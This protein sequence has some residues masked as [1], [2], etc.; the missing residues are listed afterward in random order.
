MN[1]PQ[2]LDVPTALARTLRIAQ[3]LE[4]LH[5]SQRIH[6]ALQPERLAFAPDG[7]LQLTSAP[8]A[9]VTL[10][11]ARL[12]YASPEQ[13]GRL[14]VVDARSDLH[15]L[16]LILYE[17]LL[18][19]PAF[20]SHDPLDLAYH[21]MAVAPT[22]PHALN[23]D[24]PPALSELVLRLLAKSPDARYATARGLAD[25]LQH[26]LQQLA[27]SGRI[28]PFALC[29]TDQG[30]QFLIPDRLYGRDQEIA[31][32]T[33]IF[34]RAVAGEVVLCMV[35]GYSGIGKSA[36]VRALRGNI[37]A[38][39][40]SL[41]EGKF[42]QYHRETPYSAL[43][44]AFKGLLRQVLAGRHSER[45]L[46]R[47]RI[48]AALGENISVVMDVLPELE[49][50]TG[51]Q[52]QA[53]LLIGAAAQQRFNAVFSDLLKLFASAEH[54]LVLFLDDLQWADFASLALIQSFVRA[55]RGAHLLMV[56][57]YRDNEVDAAHPMVHM[58]TE[59]RKDQAT[60]AEFLLGAL[61]VEHVAELIADTCFQIS[62]VQALAA[63]VMKKTQGNPF[64]TRQFL[65]TLVAEGRLHYD[66]CAN[67][68]R[69]ALE[70]AHLSQA[71]DNVVELM[72]RRLK[73][74][75]AADQ[76]ALKVA[77]CIGK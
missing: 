43:I 39:G 71:A 52:A 37:A 44:E 75:A 32:L 16:G 51:A 24:V 54:P 35:G 22:A 31:A 4:A 60:I 50:L 8:P 20:D 42:D 7:S 53:P 28:E 69:W 76:Q 63:L 11:L 61:S 27:R 17:W 47:A 2:P 33:R 46:W 34:H 59:L 29:A 64:Y 72:T 68:W 1:V 30:S 3:T 65:K 49:L 66:R 12:R 55:G 18:G 36:L 48:L 56:G 10:P 41:V 26:C 40:G 19:R 5:A 38:S 77:A 13:A 25:N 62:E 67:G 73:G 14:A 58:L 23:V 74:F 21:H 70:D 15:S 45:A 6:G 57:A 9:E